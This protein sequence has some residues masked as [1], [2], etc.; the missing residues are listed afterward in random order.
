MILK[1]QKL[2]AFLLVVAFPMAAQE[3][4]LEQELVARYLFNGNAR[5]E[6]EDKNH[7]LETGVDYETDRFGSDG[8]CVFMTGNNSYITIP[9]TEDL[10]WDARSKSYSILFWVKSSDPT[11]GS[12]TSRRV[13]SKWHEVLSESYPFS[14]QFSEEVMVANIFDHTSGG[15]G[16]TL[17]NPWDGEWQHVAMV[18]SHETNT[19]S[20][21]RNGE[22]V[23]SKTQSFNGT[24]S[25]NAD[26]YIGRTYTP[27]VE[28]FYQ[29]YFDDL[30]FYNRAMQ[31]CEIY[32]LYSGQLIEQR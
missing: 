25:N 28:G 20:S 27:V 1:A 16:C 26:I 23:A 7:G 24:T 8:S 12:N 3:I 21:F 32:A 30:Y 22:L 17:N 9:H 4:N 15:M 19:L 31:G 2:V 5:N 18:Y 13:L 14:F 10:N 6:V 29:G 11:G